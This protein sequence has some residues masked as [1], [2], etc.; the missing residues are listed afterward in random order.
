LEEQEFQEQASEEIK[1]L[2][3]MVDIQKYAREGDDERP[4]A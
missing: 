1:R 2:R 3:V 4:L